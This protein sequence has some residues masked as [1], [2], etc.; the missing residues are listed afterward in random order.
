MGVAA[1]WWAG[2]S[3]GEVRVV[4]AAGTTL[5][6]GGLLQAVTSEYQASHPG[7]MLSVVGAPTARVLALAEAGSVDVTITHDPEREERFISEGRAEL[8][9]EVFSSRFMLAAPPLWAQ[10]MEG[11]TP[12]RAFE[13]IARRGHLFVSRADGSGT[14][15]TERRIWNEAGVDPQGLLWYIETRQGMGL[16]LQVA[17]QRQGFVLVERSVFLVAGE[18]TDLVDAR[19]DPV[20]LANPYRAMAVK[21]SPARGAAVDFVAWLGSQEGKESVRRA[22]QQ[23]YGAQVFAP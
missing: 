7:V 21:G 12:Y 15:Q 13:L 18:V 20:G 19:L 2:C 22:N 16:T 8:A 6:D 4:V 9:A 5:V 3:R 10:G 14:Y 1:A 23:L 11:L 17:S